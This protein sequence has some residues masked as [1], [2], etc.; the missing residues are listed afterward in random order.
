M[1]QPAQMHISCLSAGMWKCRHE[2][3]NTLKIA[4][5]AQNVDLVK[6][7]RRHFF[8][9]TSYSIELGTHTRRD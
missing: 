9:Q 1:H 7:M 4:L 3:V 2:G 8:F 6:D 5:P